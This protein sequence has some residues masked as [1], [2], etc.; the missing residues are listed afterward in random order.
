LNFGPK[1]SNSKDNP[2][3]TEVGRRFVGPLLVKAYCSHDS[4]DRENGEQYAFIKT[5]QIPFLK[6]WLRSEAQRSC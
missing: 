2:E 1:I 6:E 5:G 4:V 3:V